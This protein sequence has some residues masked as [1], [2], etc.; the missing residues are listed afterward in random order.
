MQE[1]NAALSER[2]RRIGEPAVSGPNLALYSPGAEGGVVPPNAENQ[3][4]QLAARTTP[5]TNRAAVGRLLSAAL[6]VLE[7]LESELEGDGESARES[8]RRAGTSLHAVAPDEESSARTPFQDQQPTTYARGGL[9]PWQMRR[10]TTH[11]ET[12]LHE[13]ITTEDLARIARLST[14]HFARSFKRSFGESPHRYVLRR[15]TERAQGLMLTTDT[16]LGQIALDCG[17]ADQSH[18]TR[19]FQRFVG[20]SPAA[21]RRARASRR[22]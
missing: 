22:G 16:P 17:L 3:H 20:E 18:L 8:I 6:E 15:R 13:T 11:I 14:F 10:V 2:I 21:W 4:L 12:S 5:G 7:A 9:A 19:L 1:I